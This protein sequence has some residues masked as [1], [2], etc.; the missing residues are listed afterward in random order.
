MYDCANDNRL[1]TKD[2]FRFRAGNSTEVQLLLTYHDLSQYLDT[3]FDVDLVL[4]GFSKAFMWPVIII[5]CL[6]IS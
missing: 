4:F 2:Q 1:V 5:L 6:R 3:G